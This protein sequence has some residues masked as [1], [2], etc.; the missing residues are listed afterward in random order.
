MNKP[1][2]KSEEK[3][4]QILSAA[5]DLFT[6]HGLPAVSMDQ[7]AKAAGV[8]KQ[9]VY[10]HFGNKDELFTA[11]IEEKCI[12]LDMSS[13]QP[14]EGT[15]ARDTI[16]L[17]ANRFVT[18]ILSEEATQVHRTCVSEALTTPHVARVFYNTG[19]VKVIAAVA[20]ILSKMHDQGVLEIEDCHMAS[21]QLLK[22]LHGE[23]RMHAEYNIEPKISEAEIQRYTEN[24]IE[25]FIRAYS[26]RNSA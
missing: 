14:L 24:C 18:M 15:P 13:I 9:T 17:I 11:A 5:K 6:A 20:D 26:P 10:S 23:A 12:A 22:M 8:S 2:S 16:T 4:M 19:P 3:R 1:R 7:I 21:V 25:M